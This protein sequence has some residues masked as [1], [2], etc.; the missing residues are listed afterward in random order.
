MR[1]IHQ[2][3][4]VLLIV[5]SPVLATDLTLTLES[6]CE[7]PRWYTFEVRATLSSSLDN[8]GLAGFTLALTGELNGEDINL[9]EYYE[10]TILPGA[11]EADPELDPLEYFEHD[12][13]FAQPDGFAGTPVADEIIQIGGALDTIN[14]AGLVAPFPSAG[15][16]NIPTGVAHAET[17]LATIVV[18]LPRA[19]NP[20]DVHLFMVDEVQATIIRQD[21][22]PPVYQTETIANQPIASLPVPAPCFGDV[23]GSGFVD[24]ADVGLAKAYYG[25]AAGTGDAEAC[26]CDKADVNGDGTVSAHDVGLIKFYYGLCP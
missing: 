19:A 24:P 21:E 8:E 26:V 9:N 16:A 7:A 15:G 3:P 13:G 11:Y 4:L 22:T 23:N 12:L 25:C 2:A 17:A 5:G 18:H 20:G 1:V 6:T 14:N 10:V